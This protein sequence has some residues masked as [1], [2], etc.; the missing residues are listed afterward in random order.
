V[1]FLL[2]KLGKVFEFVW[3]LVKSFGRWLW[4]LYKR[5]EVQIIA[6]VEF[7]ARNAKRFCLWIWR[8]VKFV[9]GKLGDLLN[10]LWGY[11]V[12]F[13]RWLGRGLRFVL[14]KIGDGL[15]VVWEYI[16]R[17]GRW[18]RQYYELALDKI[19]QAFSFLWRQCKRFVR[20]LLVYV[21]RFIDFLF[22]LWVGFWRQV[23]RLIS[24]VWHHIG[25]FFS[26]LGELLAR[27]W[28]W[29]LPLL[30][31][32]RKV[33]VEVYRSENQGLTLQ[34]VN[35]LLAVALAVYGARLLSAGDWT[36]GLAIFV[37]SFFSY[38]WV[39][40]LL[41]KVGN[42]LVGGAFALVAAYFASLFTQ[43]TGTIISTVVDALAAGLVFFIVFP[44]LAWSFVGVFRLLGLADWFEA[45]MAGLHRWVW[46]SSLILRSV[47]A[48]VYVGTRDWLARITVEVIE[49]VYALWRRFSH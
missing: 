47:A 20:F 5:F 38:L 9:L 28:H 2:R 4:E 40:A 42:W 46:E 19:A 36:F 6:V 48:D 32:F 43:G 14:R 33:F 3:E 37:V 18:L 25:D 17:F 27:F 49:W 13:F 11:A 44:L 1:K 22:D 23:G 12:R 45:M 10:F 16:L 29:L 41:Q 21:E 31:G 39:G 26:Y 35:L 24:W 8:G 34:L 15:L 30:K 7:L